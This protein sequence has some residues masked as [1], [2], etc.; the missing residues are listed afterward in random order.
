MCSLQSRNFIPEGHGYL[1]A[2][3]YLTKTSLR[4]F[5]QF[6]PSPICV[7][8]HSMTKCQCLSKREIVKSDNILQNVVTAKLLSKYLSTNVCFNWKNGKS[9]QI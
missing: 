8:S 2:R 4:M 6:R 1:E 9:K 5:F 7:I 3:Y